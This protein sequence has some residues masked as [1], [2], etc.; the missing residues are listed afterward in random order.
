MS[1]HL[2]QAKIIVLWVGLEELP[3]VFSLDQIMN[4]KD[5]CMRVMAS[6]EVV[7]VSRNVAVAVLVTAEPHLE[8]IS[9]HRVR[10]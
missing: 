4:G 8:G 7:A 3:C 6:P 2:G 1:I 10:P 5:P 9:C